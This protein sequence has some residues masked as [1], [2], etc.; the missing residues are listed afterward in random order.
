MLLEVVIRREVQVDLLEAHDWYERQREG[1]GTQFLDEVTAAIERIRANPTGYVKVH[2]GVRRAAS[3][4]FPYGVFY[5]H[6]PGRVTVI[7][8]LHF[9]RDPELWR[10]RA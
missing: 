3:R 6:E 7:A 4:R 10:D 5:Q 1:L 2:H 9:S 8:V